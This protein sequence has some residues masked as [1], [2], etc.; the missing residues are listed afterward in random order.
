MKFSLFPI[1]SSY[2]N[3]MGFVMLEGESI[4]SSTNILIDETYEIASI[5]ELMMLKQHSVAEAYELEYIGKIH[6]R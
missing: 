2:N 4:D 3:L 5:I 6:T 1:T